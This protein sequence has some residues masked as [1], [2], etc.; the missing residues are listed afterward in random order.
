MMTRHIATLE[1]QQLSFLKA[2]RSL[3]CQFPGVSRVQLLLHQLQ[4]G[5][6]VTDPLPLS[7]QPLNGQMKDDESPPWTVESAGT[8]SIMGSP[9]SDRL[10]PMGDYVHLTSLR[11]Q[12]DHTN[13]QNMF[14]VG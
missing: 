11:N 5:R 1:D 7:V 12:N 9:S 14:D 10:G 2:V 3:Q 8:P 13:T 4:A 6:F